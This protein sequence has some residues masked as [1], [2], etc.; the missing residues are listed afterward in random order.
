[1]RRARK[2]VKY[3][4]YIGD[5]PLLNLIFSR[6]KVYVVKSEK[7]A[8]YRADLDLDLGMMYKIKKKCGFFSESIFQVVNEPTFK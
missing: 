5:S 1:M 4:K 6:D 7:Y 2:P 3:V 8:G